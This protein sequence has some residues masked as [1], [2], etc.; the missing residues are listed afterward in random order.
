MEPINLEPM[1]GEELPLGG[2]FGEVTTDISIKP[3]SYDEEVKPGPPGGALD[4]VDLANMDGQP[5]L[6]QDWL[7]AFSDLEKMLDEN[8]PVATSE[9]TNTQVV[10]IEAPELLDS[11]VCET[12]QSLAQ[13]AAESGSPVLSVD[14][15]V[16]LLELGREC[17]ENV[18]LATVDL[19]D[20]DIQNLSPGDVDSI[21]S[22]GP[23]SPASY[24]SDYDPSWSPASEDRSL[25]KSSQRGTPYSKKS[26]PNQDKKVRKMKQNREAATRYREKKRAEQSLVKEECEKLENK[27]KHL[28]DR[29]NQLSREIKYLKDL[30]C[31]VYKT[32]GTAM[33]NVLQKIMIKS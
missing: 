32:R 21:L 29:V 1:F 20:F 28:R 18:D 14:A 10:S 16:E 9:P 3:W 33:P 17:T 6:N 24:S 19:S 2:G 23:S 7:D 12:L 25:Y 5:G 27:N 11:D 26:P 31:E 30:M 4:L 13:E 15:A 22:S 8:T